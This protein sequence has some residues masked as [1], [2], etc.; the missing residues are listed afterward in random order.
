VGS[1][2]KTI[3][4]YIFDYFQDNMSSGFDHSTQKP[5]PYEVRKWVDLSQ[6]E[7]AT[8][9]TAAMMASAMHNKAQSDCLICPTCTCAFYPMHDADLDNMECPACGQVAPVPDW[10][11]SNTTH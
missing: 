5:I 11:C 1:K 9:E 4:R 2:A 8:W 6:R 3:G 10:H 7:R